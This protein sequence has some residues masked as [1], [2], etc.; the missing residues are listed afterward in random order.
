VKI[1]DTVK[2]IDGLYAD[3]EGARYK[4]LEINVDRVVLQFICQ[5]PIP[6]Q[7]VAKIDEL[8]VVEHAG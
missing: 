1:G 5:L 4:V 7:S 3:E 6:P 2:F 8:E